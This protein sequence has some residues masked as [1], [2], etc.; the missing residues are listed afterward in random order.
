MEVTAIK[1]SLHERDVQTSCPQEIRDDSTKYFKHFTSTAFH[2][3]L[4]KYFEK[5]TFP[6]S[7]NFSFSSISYGD[8]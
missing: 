6:C 3:L 1:I 4:E 2:L 7:N 5:E 8:I